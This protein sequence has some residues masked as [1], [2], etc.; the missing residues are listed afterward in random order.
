MASAG[1][2]LRYLCLQY[3]TGN[4]KIVPT[5]ADGLQFSDAPLITFPAEVSH[6]HM[7]LAHGNEVFV[8]DLVRPPHCPRH[9]ALVSES[10][11]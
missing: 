5:S 8:P 9:V 1:S 6:P 4:G 10:D 11:V 2:H 3:N 7:A